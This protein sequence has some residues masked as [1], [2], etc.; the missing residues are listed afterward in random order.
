MRFRRLPA[1]L[2]VAVTAVSFAHAHLLTFD[3]GTNY[4]EIGND[5][6]TTDGVTFVNGQY[7]DN[8]PLTFTGNPSGTGVMFSA[9]FTTITMDSA[10]GFAGLFLTYYAS[11]DPSAAIQL[12]SGLDGTG[13][14]LRT[15]TLGETASPFNV[16]PTAET[17]LGSNVAHSALFMGVANQ[18]GYDNVF[19]Q[20]PS[21]TPE[22]FTL[23]LGVGGVGAF[24]RRR[25][26]L[27]L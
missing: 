25:I 27:N 3:G 24:L 6:L 4:A 26:R 23:L 20:D 5:Y 14:L 15:L 21:S 18:V 2:A 1:I 13:T 19:F 22:P 8:P 9:N 7:Y 10:G 11:S 16:W 12:W 17:D